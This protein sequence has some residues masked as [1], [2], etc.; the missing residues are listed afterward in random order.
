MRPHFGSDIYK[1][2]DSPLTI[3][4][5]K[6]KAEIIAALEMWMQEIKVTG[7]THTIELP[8]NPIFTIT[9]TVVDGDLKDKIVLD[10]NQSG[11]VGSGTN[12]IILQAFFPPNPNNYRYQI[13]L[14][15]NSEEAAPMPNPGGYSSVAE[16][17]AWIQ[18]NWF[19]YGRWYLL[20]DKIILYMNTEGVSNAT[21]SISVLPIVRL[22][23]V[24]PVL[25]P[26]QSY[27]VTLTVNGS[28]AVP[29]IPEF[30]TVGDVLSWV[31]A[32][33]SAYGSWYIEGVNN[34]ES[35]FSDE[36]T[37]EFDLY[38]DGF[39]LI[40]VSNTEGFAGELNINAV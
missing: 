34:G 2:Q 26:D 38:N 31:Q 39:K 24:F 33:W 40:V 5:P 20:P 22:E 7:I 29:A 3:A 15:R 32:N 18:A 10:L 17:F 36:F 16:L 12:E 30:N 21:L 27:G 23:A 25:E 4:I 35:V 13:K 14:I 37:D 9:Y 11:G 19:F 28:P 1:Y 8:A 6:I